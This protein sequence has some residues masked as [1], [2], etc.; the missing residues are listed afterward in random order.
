M[1]YYLE[2]PLT[3][4]YFYSLC[5]RVGSSKKERYVCRFS[6]RG[7]DVCNPTSGLLRCKPYYFYLPWDIAG[8]IAKR[9]DAKLIIE[10]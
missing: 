2:K 8:E 3:E 5:K 7:M 10:K 4:A 6:Y 1:G 9:L